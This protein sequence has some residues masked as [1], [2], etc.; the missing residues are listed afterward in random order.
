MARL[1][2]WVCFHCICVYVCLYMHHWS[3][4]VTARLPNHMQTCSI[5][6]YHFTNWGTSRGPWPL[7]HLRHGGL[8]RQDAA[9]NSQ[10]PGAPAYSQCCCQKGLPHG[11]HG[12]LFHHVL[13]CG[14]KSVVIHFC[15]CLE[16]SVFI[17]LFFYQLCN[18]Q[19]IWLTVDLPRMWW[20]RPLHPMFHEIWC[21]G[22]LQCLWDCSFHVGHTDR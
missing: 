22:V 6:I 11:G 17:Y 12:L 3:L 4:S 9:S 2:S 20:T 13:C 15:F 16:D 10:Q 18:S 1:D 8:H 7:A 5:T 19:Y 14:K 21:P